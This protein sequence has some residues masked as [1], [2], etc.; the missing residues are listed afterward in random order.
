[1]QDTAGQERFC[2]ISRMYVRGA[3]VAILVY[4]ITSR[5]SFLRLRQVLRKQLA[6]RVTLWYL[7]VQALTCGRAEDISKFIITLQQQ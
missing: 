1:M 4:D 7:S 6:E 3:D 2:A 5:E